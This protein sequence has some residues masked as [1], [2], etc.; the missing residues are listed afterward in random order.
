MTR[1]YAPSRLHFGLLS[2]LPAVRDTRPESLPLRNY[3]GVGL[4]IHE[5]GITVAAE[6]AA[7]WSA[8]GPLAERALAYARSIAESGTRIVPCRLQIESCPPEHVGLGVGTQL[9]LAVARAVTATAGLSLNS[10]ALATLVGRGERSGIGIHGFEQGGCLIDLGKPTTATIAPSV[11]RIDWPADWW[12]VLA[13]PRIPG[14]WAG[15]RERLAFSRT[16]P[17]ET[18]M[19]LSERLCR[20]VLLGLIP[21]LIERDWKIFGQSLN[22]YN[23]LAGEPFALEQGGNYATPKVAMLIEQIQ[24]FGVSGAGQSSWGP[25]VFAVC[26]DAEQADRLLTYLQ[27]MDVSDLVVYK[28]SVCAN[29]SRVEA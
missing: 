19:R 6:P 12:L 11:L 27:S 9:G 25:T 7:A 16:R 1:V 28:T 5:P 3:G 21:A 26:Q 17:V 4:M 8:E 15:Q 2:V 13:Q 10:H 20:L 14:P 23:R 18:M 29:G 22:E 24:R